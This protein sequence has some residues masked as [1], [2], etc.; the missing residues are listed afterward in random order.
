MGGGGGEEKARRQEGDAHSDEGSWSP[1]NVTASL[2]LPP[3]QP[4]PRLVTPVAGRQRQTDRHALPFTWPSQGASKLVMT[5]FAKTPAGV[6]VGGPGI[7]PGRG[8]EGSCSAGAF[9]H[10]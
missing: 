3:G 9:A 5:G 4:S 2:L 10:S 7:D 6:E 1:L 8:R